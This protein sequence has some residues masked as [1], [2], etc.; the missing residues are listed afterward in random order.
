MGSF[1]TI[2]KSGAVGA[3]GGGLAYGSVWA[4]SKIPVT[5]VYGRMAIIAA[6]PLAI[7]VPAAAI[8]ME[9][10]SVGAMG[11]FGFQLPTVIIAAYNHYKATQAAP[12]KKTGEQPGTKGLWVGAPRDAGTPATARV[13]LRN[14]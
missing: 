1:L 6:A 2:M 12:Q 14:G 8:G 13:G 10:I 11:G 4:A 3:I 9:R 7:A 5:N